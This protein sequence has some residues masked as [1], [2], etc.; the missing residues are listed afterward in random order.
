MDAYTFI[1]SLRFDSFEP[2]GKKTRQFDANVGA[3]RRIGAGAAAGES[4]AA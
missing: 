2:V 3:A 1:D 4:G